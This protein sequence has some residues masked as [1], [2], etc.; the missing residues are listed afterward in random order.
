[1]TDIWRSFVATRICWENDWNVLFHSPTMRHDRNE[2]DLLKDFS[3]ETI[4]YL[5]NGKI[6][7]ELEKLDLE[8]GAGNIPQN[9]MKCYAEFISMGLIGKDVTKLLEAWFR[10]LQRI[11]AI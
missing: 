5:N 7:S 3:E 11:E 9:M 2:H 4:G 10:D 8:K 6:C 1:M